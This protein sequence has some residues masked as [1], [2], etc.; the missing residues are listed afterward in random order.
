MSHDVHVTNTASVLICSSFLWSIH[1]F[2]CESPSLPSALSPSVMSFSAADSTHTTTVKSTAEPSVQIGAKYSLVA[3]SRAEVSSAPH[4][5]TDQEKLSAVRERLKQDTPRVS[6]IPH[7]T[8]TLTC[9][10][11]EI[12]IH[13][14]HHVV[15]LK[16]HFHIHGA[17]F[18]CP[19][20]GTSVKH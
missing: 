9:S 10:V 16:W 2:N 20:E 12:N 15:V 1:C 6:A 17:T 7:Y 18:V 11:L 3:G 8:A 19:A 14:C 4:N 13:T 5:R